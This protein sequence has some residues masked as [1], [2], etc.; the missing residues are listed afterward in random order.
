MSGLPLINDYVC[1]SSMGK[2]NSF[3]GIGLSAGVIISLSVLYE[4]T[5][6]LDPKYSWGIMSIISVSFAI[7]SLF[8]VSEPPEGIKKE[9]TGPKI[10]SLTV[11]TAQVCYDNPHLPVGIV[12]LGVL[13]GPMIVFEIYLMSWLFGF[14]DPENGPIKE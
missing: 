6:D 8:M 9:N 10:K 11:Q 5:K 3:Q 2:A 14:Y 13:T 1:K 7:S 4:F 12:I